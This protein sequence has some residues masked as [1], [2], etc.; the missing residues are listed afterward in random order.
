MAVGRRGEGEG[1]GRPSL[2]AGERRGAAA[3]TRSLLRS[4]SCLS[5]VSSSLLPF[6]LQMFSK[7]FCLRVAVRTV[8]LCVFFG[9]NGAVN[10]PLKISKNKSTCM[11]GPG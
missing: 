3:S 11:P 8:S 6:A 4:R 7:R 5:S 2:G 1:R 9:K 10:H